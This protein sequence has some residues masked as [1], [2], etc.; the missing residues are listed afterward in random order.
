M[1]SA[2]ISALGDVPQCREVPDP[3]ER[4]G[5]VRARVRAAAVKNIER[6][7]VAGTHYGSRQL[8]LPAQV[9]LD[10][11]VEMPDGRRCYVGATPP[12]GA[13]AEWLLVDPDQ[14]IEIPVG[15]DDATAA[16]A[17]NA[18]LSAWFALEYAG[19]I[20][21]GQTV[22]VLGGTGVTGGLAV[23]LAKQHFGAGHVVAVGRDRSR[24]EQLRELGADQMLR[25]DDSK[26]PAALGE[27][28]RSAHREHRIDLVL[29]YLWG[30]PA[31]QVLNALSN[32][33]LAADFHRTRFV[34][35]GETAG[36]IVQL[37]AAALR[38][39]GVELVGQ[40]AGSVPREAFQRIG[41]EILPALF[42]MLA[43]GAIHVET[44]TRA[45]SGV[46]AAWE[47]PAPSGVR[48]VLVP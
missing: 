15:V 32:D 36:A 27:A 10:A 38:S 33:D 45:L 9:G 39:A 19:R 17:P 31:E 7:L 3:P 26:D 34:Q 29:D 30:V 2:M 28:V 40:G 41:N 25:L 43:D 48:T 6:M 1:K 44:R 14:V 18:A 24:L 8:G 16:A 46:A 4:A 47:E 22:L 37:P 13:M 35:I 11:V 21:P 12:A 42:A 23:Q 5:W 20:R